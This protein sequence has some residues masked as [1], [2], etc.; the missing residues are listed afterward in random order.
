MHVSCKS[1]YVV[2]LLVSIDDHCSLNYCLVTTLKHQLTG[3]VT[4]VRAPPFADHGSCISA[5]RRPHG[6]GERD[7][8][9]C[10]FSTIC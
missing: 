9:I 6:F 1:Y 8:H 3:G 7:G 4:F 5:K 2:I 10:V